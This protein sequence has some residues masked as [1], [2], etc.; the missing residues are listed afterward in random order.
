[1]EIIRTA[2]RKYWKDIWSLSPIAILVLIGIGVYFIIR[3][4]SGDPDVQQW[5]HKNV[6]DMEIIDVFIVGV[7][8]RLIG[9]K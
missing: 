5:L 8:I 1:M 6:S 2:M 4:I 7:L 9:S 3:W